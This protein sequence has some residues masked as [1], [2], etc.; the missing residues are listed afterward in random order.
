MFIR[1]PRLRA[2][3]PLA[4]LIVTLATAQMASGVLRPPIRDVVEVTRNAH[5]VAST[6]VQDAARNADSNVFADDYQTFADDRLTSYGEDVVRACLGG[7]L[8]R[9]AGVV[10]SLTAGQSISFQSTM[11][12]LLQ[13]C[14][15]QAFPREYGLAASLS[16]ALAGNWTQGA[17]D[18]AQIYP[19]TGQLASWLQAES[20][21]Q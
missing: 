3:M 16:N 4:A 21:L 18:F 20:R 10:A 17:I 1:S 7:A 19:S 11:S 14:I 15:T 9:I 8:S 12:S 13:A 5:F 6:D 2:L